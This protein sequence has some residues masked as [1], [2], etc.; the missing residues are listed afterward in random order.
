MGESDDTE[1]G[2]GTM[3]PNPKK[4]TF[5]AAEQDPAVGQQARGARTSLDCLPSP[6]SRPVMHAIGWRIVGTV[7]QPTEIR[8]QYESEIPHPPRGGGSKRHDALFHYLSFLEEVP[9]LH[10]ATNLIP[11]TTR[12]IQMRNLVAY[13]RR[14]ERRFRPKG[15]RNHL[16][17][18]WSEATK[19]SDPEARAKGRERLVV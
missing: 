10:H 6:R 7:P 18:L 13:F 8:Y 3:T 12:G 16:P 1:P 4:K 17:S 19:S 11:S 2:V 14:T 5:G 15:E 9:F